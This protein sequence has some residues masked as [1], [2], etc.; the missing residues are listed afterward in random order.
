MKTWIG[1]DPSH[2]SFDAAFPSDQSERYTTE[3]YP[4]T[5]EGYRSFLASVPED[6]QILVEA[7]GSYSARLLLW[8]HK[9]K[10]SV[11]VV[12]STQ[13]YGFRQME[14]FR[15]KTDQQDAIAIAR[16]GLIGKPKA[17]Q[18][19]QPHMVKLRQLATTLALM[20]RHRTSLKNQRH[21]FKLDPETDPMVL[22]IIDQALTDHKE[23]IKTLEE[24]IEQLVKVHAKPEVDLLQSISGIGKR[25]AP[26][27]IALVQ[28]FNRFE[29]GR[30]LAAFFGLTPTTFRSGKSI[31]RKPKISKIGQPY[32][33]KLLYMCACS[34]IQHNPICREF[35]QKLLKK[36]KSKNSAIMAVAHK[37]VRIAFAVVKNNHP[38]D[39][40]FLAKS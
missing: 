34:A 31:W 16:Y 20:I 14:G 38:F 26:I 6:A 9:H 3:N 28:D 15:A 22:E 4:Q 36:G 8:I 21:A 24:Q 18:P 17:W 32:M 37:L 30:Q 2:E 19:D 39:P 29:S 12:N 5:E 10:G 33:R 27:F 7:T 23:K 13:I 11:Y 1:I 40:N 35:Y 25:T